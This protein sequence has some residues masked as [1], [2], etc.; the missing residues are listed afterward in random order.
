MAYSGA[1]WAIDVGQCAL[2][3][4]RC[5]AGE[6]LGQVEAVAFDYIEYP[7]IL[8]QPDAD[9]VELIADALKQFLSRNE[10]QG[11]RVAISVSGQSGLA[12]FIKLPPVESKKIPDIVRYEARQ[13]IPFDLSDVV[14]DYQQMGGSEEEGFSLETEIGLFAMKREAVFRAIEPFRDVGIEVDF[15]QLAPLSLYNYIVFDKM[16]SLP[17]A[18]EYAP[19]NPPPSIVILSLGTDAID[20]VVT[21]GF[22]VWQRSVPIGGNHFTM[23]LTKSL[24]LTFAKAEHLKR[25]AASAQDSKAIYQAMRPVFKDLVTE[26]QR[27]IGYF[28]NIDRNAKIDR[29]VALGNAMKL[30]GLRK[31][32]EKSLGFRVERVDSYRAMVGSQV[33]SAPAFK[34]NILGFGTCYG[35]ALQGLAM[36]GLRTNLLPKEIVRERMIRKKKPWVVAAAAVLLLGLTVN[37]GMAS[38]ALRTVDKTRFSAA[39]Q[40]AEWIVGEVNAWEAEAEAATLKF[41]NT[42]SIG[43]HLVGS[44]EGRILWLELMKMLNECMPRDL[45]TDGPKISIEI[46]DRNELHIRSIDCQYFDDLS[47][48]FSAVKTTYDQQ[49][50]SET[51]APAAADSSGEGNEG[52]VDEDSQPIKPGPKGGGWVVQLTGYHYHNRQ[53]QTNAS[54]FVHQTFIANL[55]NKKVKLEEGYPLVST[56]AMGI[57][58]PVL[59]MTST[60]QDQELTDPGAGGAFEADRGRHI[61][62]GAAIDEGANTVKVKRIDFVVQFC[63]QPAP[64]SERHEDY[65]G[66]EEGTESPE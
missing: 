60:L 56:T 4:L 51:G 54:E 63:W 44:V 36:G 19:E 8:S 5:M 37:F 43:E 25:N 49:N 6:I 32:L 48:W 40:K 2:K 1:V 31:Y 10:V 64:P 3:A 45:Q 28:G 24:K 17:P 55:R 12:R 52:N 41:D 61:P 16:P 42:K 27:S 50:K 38:R 30:P 53:S 33:L 9:P 59:F 35:L 39:E 62:G 20:L 14:W 29:I 23:A 18:D 46:A 7:K 21:N 65:E 58:Y 66:E 57:S 11:D 15:V 34:D 13:Q 47:V 26:L 22:R